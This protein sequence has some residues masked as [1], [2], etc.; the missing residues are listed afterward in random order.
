M[1]REWTPSESIY[2]VEVFDDGREIDY[3][4]YDDEIYYVV[5]N[6]FSDIF[7]AGVEPIEFDDSWLIPSHWLATSY[8]SEEMFLAS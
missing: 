2:Q 1:A 5:F 3:E 4:L 7:L 8:V 6:K